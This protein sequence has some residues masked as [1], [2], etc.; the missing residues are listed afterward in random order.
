M[1]TAVVAVIL[2]P[3]TMQ[4]A[5]VSALGAASVPAAVAVAAVQP[6]A[7]RRCGSWQTYVNDE[8]LGE[9]L[10]HAAIIGLDGNPKAVSEGFGLKDGEGPA[11]VANFGD[12]GARPLT[13][14]GVEYQ[15]TTADARSIY[16]EKDTGGAITAKTAQTVVIGIYDESLQPVHAADSVEELA[17]HLIENGC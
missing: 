1:A 3:L 2:L 10:R 4:P 8:L 5:P 16:G 7:V 15:L 6:A 14:G 17:Y 11:L 13:I 9:G 12:P